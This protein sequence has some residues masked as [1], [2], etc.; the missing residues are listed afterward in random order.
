MSFVL[1]SLLSALCAAVLIAGLVKTERAYQYPFLACALIASFILP[2]LPGIFADPAV[3]RDAL[4]KALLMTLLCLV[5]TL[6][7]W[8]ASRA[9]ARILRA[10]FDER[11]LGHIAIAFAL[12]SSLF[13]YRLSQL[14]GD[15]I[16]G[17]QISGAPVIYLFFAQLMPYG[18]AISCLLYVRRPSWSMLAV[19]GFCLLFYLQRIV[20]TGK[21]A[22]TMELVLIFLLAFWFYRGRKIG[23]TTLILGAV[24]GMVIMTSMSAY[25]DIT[26]TDSVDLSKV[27][28]IDAVG[29]FDSLIEDGGEEMRNAVALID[30]T[31]REG[32]FDYGIVHWNFIV[33]NF[34]PAQIVGASVKQ[35]ML[36]EKPPMPRDFNPSTG[37]TFTGMTDAFRSFWYLGALEFL[38]LGYVMRRLWE[39]AMEGQL[40]GRIIYTLSAVPATHAFSHTTDWVLPVWIHMLIF[41]APAMAYAYRA[42]DPARGVR[43]QA[44]SSRDR[45]RWSPRTAA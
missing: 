13:Y 16:V 22:E 1:V 4:A 11:R 32:R 44:Q 9:P 2:Q 31:D 12:V 6:T 7:G 33:W 15:A 5:G 40:L 21:R 24:A 35:S 45:L 37:T 23:R 3:P 43:T 34:L 20:V 36:L 8:H 39:S 25:R 18:L 29:N 41:L 10:D 42:P 38:F 28:Q 17:V 30:A 27:A 19:I 14:P 26:R